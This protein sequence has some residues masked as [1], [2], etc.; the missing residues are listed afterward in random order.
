[1]K[2]PIGIQEF[3]KIIKGNYIYVDKTA[4]IYKLVTE[5]S[6]YFLSRP[7]RFGKSLLVSTLEAYFK[8]RKELFAGL[9][10]DELE[11]EWAEYPVFHIDFNG[12]NFIEPGVLEK[13]IEKFLTDQEDIYGRNPNSKETGSRFKDILKAAHQKTGKRAVVLIDE[14]DKPILDVLDTDTTINIQGEQRLL[15][16]HHRNI[17]KGF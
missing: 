13:V 5:G 1:M 8:G 10:I 7:R 17:L 16:D 6:I 2:Y 9:A 11:S 4:L 14:Y 15:E 12:S 3:E